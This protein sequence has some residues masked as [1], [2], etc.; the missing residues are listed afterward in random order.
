M[1]F[2]ELVE[3]QNLYE[4]I[5]EDYSDATYHLAYCD[6]DAPAYKDRVAKVAK[7]EKELQEL[8]D[9]PLGD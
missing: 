2:G 6:K 5:L 9:K 8:R 1:T 7:L 4:L 3:L